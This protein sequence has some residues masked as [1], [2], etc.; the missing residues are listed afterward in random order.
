MVNIGTKAAAAR[1]A[2]RKLGRAGLGPREFF[3]EVS[4]R[5]RRVVPH[6][7]YGWS[8]L[9]PDTM[10]L[11]SI[12]T[13]K[14]A[15]F[16]QQ[17]LRNELLVT[18]VQKMA[19]L[20][21]RPSPVAS[22][23]QLDP[24]SAAGSQRLQLIHRPVGIGDELR[25]VLRSGGSAWGGAFLYRARDSRGFDARERAFMADVAAE[26]G[27]GLRR[28]LARRPEPGA[29]VLVPGV[30]AFGATG[31]MT[32]A[33]AE[34]RQ[35]MALM[36]GDAGMTLSYLAVSAAQADSTRARSRVRLSDGRWLLLHGGRLLGAPEDSAQVTVTL[37]PA[38]RA[39]VTSILLRLHG[40]SA[41]ERQV[42]ELL[43]LGPPT[44]AIAARLHIS[45]HTLHDHVKSIFAKVGA[46][47][48]S[49]LMALGSDMEGG[50]R[51]MS[52]GVSS[53]A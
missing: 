45:P 52:D 6:D 8:T 50:L 13:D 51:W 5:V 2:V 16:L 41:R 44:D 42:A 35:L 26:I 37:T 40:L 23:S 29:A 18:D 27:E 38:P 11:T 4:A 3:Y 21:R 48:R 28:S 30:V 10:L 43:M 49:E 46:R 22:L 7:M 14:P 53:S 15:K 31:A 39:D 1:D 19:E 12:D 17:L 24:V 20:A 34:A 32:S 33:T 47:S 25:T 36:P 9:D